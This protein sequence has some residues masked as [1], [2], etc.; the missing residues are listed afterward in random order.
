MPKRSQFS[1][2]DVLLAAAA[3]GIGATVGS[4]ESQ[5]DAVNDSNAD[6]RERRRDAERLRV[7][8]AQEYS[9]HPLKHHPTNRD[10][11]E[12]RDNKG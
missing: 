12:L 6:L 4:Q 11:D 3:A 2:R 1:R 9:H 7:D 8:L 10:E 5:A